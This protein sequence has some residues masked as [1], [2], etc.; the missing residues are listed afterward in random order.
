MSTPNNNETN[1]SKP[2]LNVPIKGY[3]ALIFA[4]TFF[5]GILAAQKGWITVFDFNTLNGNF[6]TMKNNAN[7][8]FRGIAGTGARDGFLFALTLVPSVMLALGIIQVVDHLG[9]LRAAQK[10][11]TPL[12]RPVLGI[13]GIT[14]LAL[15][16][17]LQSMDASAGMARALREADHITEKEKTIFGAFC[18]SGGGTI[19]NYFAIVVGL[20]S[21]YTVPIG[22]PLLVVFIFKVFGTNLMRLYLNRFVK[23]EI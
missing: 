18:F 16:A 14:G 2:K 21:V 15:I 20:F 9:G 10:L 17:S 11:L 22:L 3:I 12:L 1:T 23:E 19:T 4:I 6:G 7:A 8:V 5:S 13:P